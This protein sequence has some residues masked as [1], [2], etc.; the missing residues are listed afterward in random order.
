MKKQELLIYFMVL[1]AS[2]IA[3]LIIL[4]TDLNP[5]KSSFELY[6]LN[7]PTQVARGQNLSFSVV[8]NA[9]NAR[10]L[11]T[12]TVYFDGVP[13]KLFKIEPATSIIQFEMRNDLAVGE[14]I[15]KVEAYDEMEP[16]NHY[17]SSLYP[18]YIFFRVD[19][20]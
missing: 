6:F 11:L 14:H 9:E 20:R 16:A 4:S 17:G 2:I 10:N 15:V 1:T 7:Y 8:L 5:E 12:M 19:V 18:Y 13:Q 3:S